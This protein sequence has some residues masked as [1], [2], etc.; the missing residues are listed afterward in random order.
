MQENMNSP[1]L[2]R[3]AQFV[4]ERSMEV[5]TDNFPSTSAKPQNS[6]NNI[7]KKKPPNKALVEAAQKRRYTSEGSRSTGGEKQKRT[8]RQP[9]F[10]FLFPLC[11]S[12]MSRTIA[13]RYHT[14]TVAACQYDTFLHYLGTGKSSEIVRGQPMLLY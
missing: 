4:R 7:R 5:V 9:V 1:N 6:N 8:Q 10:T 3:E 13:F 2:L 14:C 11:C 12:C